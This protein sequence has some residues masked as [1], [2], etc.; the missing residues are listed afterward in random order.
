MVSGVEKNHFPATM[1]LNQPQVCRDIY[2]ERIPASNNLCALSNT[3]IKENLKLSLTWSNGSTNML[4]EE[5]GWPHIL[6]KKRYNHWSLT[7][8]R[9]QCWQEDT[10]RWW[11]CLKY[12]RDWKLKFKTNQFKTSS[13]QWNT[14]DKVTHETID[15]SIIAKSSR[16]I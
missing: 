5:I 16:C 7:M 11:R 13:G 3:C 2:Y 9:G 4:D 10:R 8:I 1:M 12:P 14:F 15:G 6:Y